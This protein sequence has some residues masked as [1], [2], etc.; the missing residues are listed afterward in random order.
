ML[1]KRTDLAVEAHEIWRE[2]AAVE[3]RLSGVEA[4]DY[5]R[6][7][8]PVTHVKILDEKGSKELG[9]PIGT[10]VTVDISALSHGE[11]SVFARTVQAISGELRPL[12]PLQ[13]EGVALVVGLGNR[14][15][16]PDAIG[17]LTTEH[18]MVTRH[19]VEKM[20]DMFG[21]LR[22]VAALTPGVLGSTGVESADI[23]KGVVDK[24][25]PDVVVMVDALAS[26][27][28]SRICTTVQLADTGIVPGSGVGNARAAL[29][30]KTLGVPVIAV[31]VP[32]VVD[33]ATLCADLLEEAGHGE[34]DPQSLQG[35]GGKMIVTPKEIDTH[36]EDI[37]RA[38]GYA[39]NM[40]LHDGFSVAEITDF[41][42]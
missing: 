31:G 6:E 37:A 18:L 8:C 40:S 38:V 32:T 16:T 42:S 13:P 14:D 41:L 19:L 24:V 20:P 25:R 15:I 23:I 2:S 5:R 3:T 17:P 12:L 35:H 27:K 26:R 34:I 36:V 29:N 1:T 39:I 28:L 7:G 30:R 22:P 33:A 11:P 10:Y 4:R 21:A 9:K